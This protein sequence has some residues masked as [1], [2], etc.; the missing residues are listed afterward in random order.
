MITNSSMAHPGR[1]FTAAA[2]A[3]SLA[4]PVLA[5]CGG[6]SNNGANLP[7]IDDTRGTNASYTPPVPEQSHQGMTTKQKIV[8]VAGAAALYW[9]YK[10]QKDQQGNQVQYYQSKNGRI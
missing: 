2:I 7:P 3:A 6:P 5:G 9:L 1:R 8:L 4:L 10:H